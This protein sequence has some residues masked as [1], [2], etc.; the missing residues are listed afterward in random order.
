MNVW[1]FQNRFLRHL[2]YFL[3]LPYSLQKIK[4]IWKC[5]SPLYSFY[6]LYFYVFDQDTPLDPSEQSLLILFMLKVVS[7]HRR[8]K[9]THLT[10]L[11]YSCLSHSDFLVLQPLPF[12][13][14]E[15]PLNLTLLRSIL[16]STQWSQL[17]RKYEHCLGLQLLLDSPRV[18]DT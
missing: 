13:D 9:K 5:I 8:S 18:K 6:L 7:S 14:S 4:L 10:S 3:F 16:C 2:P 1:I 17:C 12:P 15:F 11:L